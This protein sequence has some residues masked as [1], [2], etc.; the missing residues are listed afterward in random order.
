MTRIER[1]TATWRTPFLSLVY[2]I[3]HRKVEQIAERDT[4][5]AIEPLEAYGRLPGLMIGYAM[6]ESATAKAN[7]ADQRLK[8]LGALKAATL[9]HCEYCIDIAS[10]IARK[11][12]LSDAQLLALPDYKQ[13]EQFSDLEKLVLDY[14]VGISR[15]PVEVPDELFESL[16]A[17]FD[18][19]QI[20]E[21][22]HE[23]ALENM[24]SRFNTALGIGSAGLTEG[25]VCA[26]PDSPDLAHTS[27]GG[28]STSAVHAR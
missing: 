26:V 5:R 6:L 4:P 16:R 7:R 25:M 12:G 9:S 13:S 3:A 27:N 19:R 14:A 18:D 24:R 22:T 2:R 8:D 17:H 15:T 1:A 28:G 23:I 11:S 10:S 21:L 20:V